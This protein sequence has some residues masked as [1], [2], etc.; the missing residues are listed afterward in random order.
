[1]RGRRMSWWISIT[2][3]GLVALSKTLAHSTNPSILS[4]L[5]ETAAGHHF[6]YLVTECTLLGQK[7][8]W[9]VQGVYCNT[10][11]FV[12]SVTSPWL[13]W[14]WLWWTFPMHAANFPS[15]PP[16]RLSVVLLSL[17]FQEVAYS[18]Q[19]FSGVNFPDRV[20]QCGWELVDKYFSLCPLEG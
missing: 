12:P 9:V 7:H 17:K 15:Q 2:A 16:Q 5:L 19:R 1:M 8:I 20:N 18:I 6:E 13:T 3:L 10:Y 11:C 4:F 14:L